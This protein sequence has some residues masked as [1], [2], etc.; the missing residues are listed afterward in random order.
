M[1]SSLLAVSLAPLA[2]LCWLSGLRF[3]GTELAWRIEPE[4]NFRF[5]QPLLIAQC[6]LDIKWTIVYNCRWLELNCRWLELRASRAR[7]VCSRGTGSG[8]S[9]LVFG[10]VVVDE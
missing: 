6:P 4:N 10:N 8:G 7:I 3:L 2:S 5:F 1:A 9:R